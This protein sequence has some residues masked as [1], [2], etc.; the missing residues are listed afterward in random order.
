[1]FTRRFSSYKKYAQQFK[2]KPGS[3]MTSFAIL[4]ELTA[5]APFPFIYFALD[6]SNLKIPFPESVVSEGNRFINKARVYYKYEPLEAD[7]RVMVNLVTTYCIVKALL[8]VRLA[9]SVA[10]TPFFAEKLIGPMFQFVR[11]QF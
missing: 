1:M 3:Y 6:N 10:M 8:P 4:H 5:V 2:S 9:A 11:K 7:N